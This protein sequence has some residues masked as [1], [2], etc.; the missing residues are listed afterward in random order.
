MNLTIITN[1]L[2]SKDKP[3]DVSGTAAANVWIWINDLILLICYCRCALAGGAWGN[4]EPEA[5]RSSPVEA[6][7]HLQW[8]PASR[9]HLG[10][11]R[12][13]SCLGQQVQDL[14]G[15]EDN[16]DSDI[17]V[18]ALGH[19]HIHREGG[20]RGRLGLCTALTHSYR[21]VCSFLDY[22]SPVTDD[23]SVI[24]RVFESTLY[25]TR[26]PRPS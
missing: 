18:G 2:D 14:C 5:E 3:N 17:L 11:E 9:H 22:L 7:G 23:H 19:C 16:D 10:E 8:V 20:Q 1:F 25:P 12:P 24:T 6:R 13:V 15:R 4:A 26:R 21:W